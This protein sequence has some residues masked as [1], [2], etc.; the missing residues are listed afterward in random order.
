LGQ[1]PLPLRDVDIEGALDAL[2]R[3][4][5]RAA[6]FVVEPQPVRPGVR[7][8]VDCEY[9]RLEHFEPTAQPAA[10]APA[11]GPHCLHALAG[12]ARLQRSDGRELGTLARGESA[13]V[14]AGVG[15][16]RVLGDGGAA[17]VVR[18]T[19]PPYGD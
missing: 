16:Y 7:R 17:N 10:G 3:T 6:E 2:N 11:A 12:R 15:A 19:L 14:P 18:V 13:F 4:A 9:F 5:T 8:S 1:R